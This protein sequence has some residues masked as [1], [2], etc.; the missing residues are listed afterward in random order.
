MSRT[1]RLLAL[2]LLAASSLPACI[3]PAKQGSGV[4]DGTTD[5]TTGT[6]STGPGAT[7]PVTPTESAMTT[8]P[9]QTT[10]TDSV[11]DGCADG[12]KNGEE[13]D[14]DCGGG[15]C[16]R[17]GD[18]AACG[19]DDD[20]QSALCDDTGHCFPLHPS[21]LALHTARPELPSGVYPLDPGGA[22]A[23]MQLR[24]DMDPASPGWT[25]IFAPGADPA[26]WQPY[27][28]GSCG[29][30]GA[31]IGPFGTGESLT[32][33]PETHGVPHSE[34]R[35]VGEA[36]VM[37]SW[38]PFES[39]RLLIELGDSEIFSQMCDF[40]SPA[41]CNQEMHHCGDQNFNDGVLPISVVVPH[42]GVDLW[43]T[44]SSTLTEPV[45]NESWGVRD[46]SVLVK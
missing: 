40:E 1:T 34:V 37:D 42:A 35:L 45:D 27:K 9:T 38:D 25:E 20:C 7:E 44:F 18:D 13:T 43:L 19:D 26:A 30:L 5:E 23:V 6:H 31:M 3:E 46:V 16:G 11:G 41:I 28:E 33:H 22:G 24:C 14:I 39:D 21:C 32:L 4:T 2:A 29:E 10:S 8:G 12:E 17:C 36:V 15:V